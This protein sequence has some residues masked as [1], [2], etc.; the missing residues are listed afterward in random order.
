MILKKPYAF[1]IKHFKVIH[2]ILFAIILYI[3]YRFNKIYSF[4]ADYV[5][6]NNTVG[7]TIA[8]T[9]IPITIFLAVF[10][11]IVFS[12]LMWLL[13]NNKKKPS[14][15][16][17]ITG[18]YYFIIFIAIILAYNV[19]NQLSTV[20]LTQRASRAYRDIYQILFFPNIYFLIIS[21]IRG[22]GFDVKKFN[23]SKDLEE[24]EIKSEDNEEFEFVLGNDSYKRKRKIRR[25]LREVK[26]Y[27]IENKFFISII[28]GAI[29][30]IG[31]I[32]FL[33]NVTLFKENYHVGN[34]LKTAGFYYKLNH[35]YLSCYDLTGKKI[36]EDKKYLILDLNIRSIGSP[37]SIKPEDFYL[38]KGKNTYNYKTSLSDSF[39]DI[40]ITYKGDSISTEGDNYI[41]VFEVDSKSKGEFT[42]TIFD[43]LNYKNNKVEYEYKNYKFTPKNID[44]G[45]TSTNKNI[46]DTLTF[47][48]NVFGDTT[49][50]IKNIIISNSFE[51]KYNNC[52]DENNCTLTSDIIF[53]NDSTKNSLL[54]VEYNLNIDKNS[55]IYN[56]VGDNSGAFISKFIKATYT[57]QGTT[58]LT[59]LSPR[60]NQYIDN[61]IFS[62][63]SKTIQ[64]MESVNL[65]I[66]TRNENYIINIK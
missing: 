53:P 21:L 3:T 61:V 8:N 6:N 16:Y 27:I 31:L 25:N 15:F 1:L 51:Y 42:L 12:I 13:M 38:V 17:L 44:N 11:V 14:K 37:N 65:V 5:S 40:G 28:A 33:L 63:F 23:F 7:V 39:S 56:S 52:V 49:L 57:H 48:K 35:A 20:T 18:L 9:Y 29:L 50:I 2:L 10:V 26:Y 47:N 32:T 60:T 54:I 34:T 36:K 43:Q 55:P 66:S 64:N 58:Y 46:N 4:F 59:S 19:I 30:I 62:D 22:I 24:L 45:Y 41:F